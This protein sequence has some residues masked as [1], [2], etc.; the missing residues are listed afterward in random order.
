MLAASVVVAAF[1]AWRLWR[2]PIALGFVTPRL[3]RALS[4]PDGSLSVR[5]AATEVAWDA[6]AHGPELRVRDVRVLTGRDETVARFP[7]L[8]VGLSGPALLR[9]VLAPTTVVLLGPQLRLVREADGG[10]DLWAGAGVAPARG[11]T[12]LRALLAPPAPGPAPRLQSV[13]VRD[14]ELTVLDRQSKQEWRLHGVEAVLRRLEEGLTLRL[15]GDLEAGDA[16]VPVRAHGLYRLDGV[17]DA[18]AAASQV[19]IGDLVRC[20]PEQVGGKARS[21]LASR[22]HR[23]LVR[24]GRVHLRGR[25]SDTAFEVDTVSGRLTFDGLSARLV[26]GMPPASGVAGTDGFDG[27]GGNVRVARGTLGGMEIV[28]A[29]VHVSDLDQNEPRLAVR[30]ATRGTIAHALALLDAM[31]PGYGRALVPGRA[32]VSGSVVAELALTHPL[33][34]SPAPW[35]QGLVVSARLHDVAVPHAFRGR[36]LDHGDLRLELH[37]R[38]LR[39]TGHAAIE[40]APVSLVWQEE[41][42]AAAAARRLDVTG[43]V[44]ATARAALGLDLRPWL[45][46]PAE[47]RVH[48]EE[49]GGAGTADI[50]VDF[51]GATVTVPSLMLAKPAGVPGHAEARLALTRGIPTSV[52]RMVLQTDGATLRG[53][54][55]LAPD[56]TAL[57][58]LDVHATLGASSPARRPAQLTLSVG[59]A[60]GGNRFLLTSDDAGI[61]FRAVEPESEAKG[62]QL[63]F[64]G[65]AWHDAAGL[66][67]QGRLEVRDFTLTRAP[68]LTRIATLASLT[69]ITRS[70]RRGDMVWRQL[71]ADIEHRGTLV[72]ITDGR[73]DGPDLTVLFDGMIDRVAWTADL[74]GT[75]VPSYYGLNTAAGRVPVL[76]K[77]VTGPGGE[78]VQVFEVAVR[79][80][81]AAP[82]VSV[83][84]LSALAPG[85]L[86]DL[87]RRLPGTRKP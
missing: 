36:S 23:G 59:S 64:E 77:L 48:R 9:G 14:G 68:L 78:G 35:S 22:I 49:L 56:R 63:R 74:R 43:R 55:T 84:A 38:L 32:G 53:R 31:P 44:D 83:N 70:L 4:R 60:K 29:S 30:A 1:L 86:R 57:R 81:L 26:D 85:A 61:V 52:D 72:T 20:W 76:G 7:A 19:A 17:V 12:T 8:A 58:D 33:A 34:G 87:L 66:A 82:E 46:G 2:G 62:G 21:A 41:L 71:T 15:G 37:G 75:L 3:E 69:G 25:M 39:M 10:V 16:V 50:A 45:D 28:H 24:E 73:L 51:G 6:R 80:P 79:G 40:G 65:L 27:A 42:G 5:I 18:E 67:L 47:V 13:E 54:A 11:D